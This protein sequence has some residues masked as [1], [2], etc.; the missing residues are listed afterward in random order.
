MVSSSTFTETY[1]ILAYGDDFFAGMVSNGIESTKELPMRYQFVPHS[2]EAEKFGTGAMDFLSPMFLPESFK[3]CDSITSLLDVL[4]LFR[5]S[6]LI[7]VEKTTVTTHAIEEHLIVSER[8][9]I[10]YQYEMISTDEL[11]SSLE[12]KT[13]SV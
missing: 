7:K 1:F 13:V 5:G 2:N 11:E 6:R 9:E 8:T 3:D 10:N 4:K 12:K